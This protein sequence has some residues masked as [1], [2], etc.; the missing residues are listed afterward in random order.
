MD[1]NGALLKNNNQPTQ[2]EQQ[3]TTS[4]LTEMTVVSEFL[5]SHNDI[6]YYIPNLTNNNQEPKTYSYYIPPPLPPNSHLSEVYSNPTDQ[7]I[8]LL[9]SP[10]STPCRR[11]SNM[12]ESLLGKSGIGSPTYSTTNN[13]QHMNMNIELERKNS[14]S[15]KQEMR[16]EE[17][18]QELL[19]LL[20]R[21]IN[22]RRLYFTMVDILI[23][24]YAIIAGFVFISSATTSQ[25]SISALLTILIVYGLSKLLVSLTYIFS[26]LQT[27]TRLTASV[28]RGFQIIVGIMT[29]FFYLIIIVTTI[30]IGTIGFYKCLYLNNLIDYENAQSEFYTTPNTYRT[31][32]TIFTVQMCSIVINCCCCK[33]HPSKYQSH[34]TTPKLHHHQQPPHKS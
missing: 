4:P 12:N 27:K 3:T 10:S 13:T 6:K 8:S 11:H 19:D 28:G 34:P 16:K 31:T 9:S 24:S 33:S 1:Q 29:V 23:A 5:S 15:M 22:S 14:L 2:A 21:L 20:D 7:N 25:P 26:Y 18:V 17:I 32:L 30:I